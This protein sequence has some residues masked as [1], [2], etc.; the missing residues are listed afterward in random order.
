MLGDDDNKAFTGNDGISKHR[1][2]SFV[3]TLRAVRAASV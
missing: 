2:Y 3:E 1:K